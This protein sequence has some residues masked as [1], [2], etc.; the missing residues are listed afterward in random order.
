MH[1]FDLVD[2]YVSALI[3]CVCLGALFDD[4]V[5]DAQQMLRF[6]IQTIQNQ[7][8]DRDLSMDEMH[9][10]IAYGNEFVASK[11]LCRFLRVFTK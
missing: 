9:A 11:R 6:A 1:V 3:M 10:K 4:N 2:V 7:E 5:D 8:A